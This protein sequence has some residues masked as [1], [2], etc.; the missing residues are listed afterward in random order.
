M[1]ILPSSLEE[2][3]ALLAVMKQDET[4]VAMIL[5]EVKPQATHFAAELS[6]PM[7]QSLKRLEEML[8]GVY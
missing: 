1:S 7:H 2:M 5:V 8:V 6:K 3:P 4:S